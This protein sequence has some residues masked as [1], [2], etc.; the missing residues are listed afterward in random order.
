MDLYYKAFFLENPSILLLID[1]ETGTIADASNVACQFYGYSRETLQQMHITDINIFEDD[2]V[3]IEMKRAKKEFQ[4]HFYFR[5]RLSS[6]EFRDVEV[7]SS[8]V[9]IDG[10]RLLASIIQDRTT[11]K[12]VESEL[13]SLNVIGEALNRKLTEAQSLYDEAPCGYHSLDEEGK[14]IRMNDTELK[15][16]GYSREELVGKMNFEE[17]LDEE[18]K[19]AFK[20]NFDKFIRKGLDD[21]EDQGLEKGLEFNLLCKNGNKLPVLINR[22]IRYDQ[23][24]N[25]IMSRSTVHDITAQKEHESMLLDLNNSLERM[26]YDRTYQLEEMNA[27]LEEM[28][29]EFEE[30]NERLEDTNREYETSNELLIET[31]RALAQEIDER[32]ATELMLLK[33]KEEAENANQAK[34]Q[35]LANMSHEIRTPLN[36]I[37]GMTDLLHMTHLD[38]EQKNYV[39]L[40]KSSSKVLLTV[41]NDI[42]D[43]SKIEAGK[44]HLEVEDFDMRLLVEEVVSLFDISAKQKGIQLNSMIDPRLPRLLSGDVVRIRQVLSNIVGNAVKFTEFGQINISIGCRPIGNGQITMLLSVE[45]S[46]IGI[47]EEDIPKLFKRFSQ[48]EDA[49]HKR[50][51]GTGLGLVISKRLVEMMGGDIWVESEVNKGSTFRFTL[52]LAEVIDTKGNELLFSNQAS[53]KKDGLKEVLLVEDDEISRTLGRILVE[54]MGLKVT[55]AQNGLEGLRKYKENLFDLILMDVNMPELDGISAT[56]KIREME[57]QL[58]GNKSTPII[59]MTAFAIRGDREKCLQAGMNDYISKPIDIGELQRLVKIYLDN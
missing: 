13:E 18:S 26:V 50:F 1:P 15:W 54:K 35:F 19:E 33:A 46:G 53:E 6:G 57:G 9:E 12:H 24:G 3:M 2:E 8:P 45:D 47:S 49:A 10:R 48:V 58:R 55:T 16:L 17:L 30:V 7:N 22:N 44:M 38:A 29:A 39:K 25:F 5:H 27:E 23:D 59:A 4:K 40:I 21:E 31:N 51:G 14:I 52:R 32:E 20:F 43:Y 41:I 11:L 28:N 56:M 34:S 37:I 42:L 36:G